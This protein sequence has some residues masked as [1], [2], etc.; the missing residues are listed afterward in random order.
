MKGGQCHIMLIHWRGPHMK[1]CLGHVHD[2]QLVHISVLAEVSL[3]PSSQWN[4]RPR[5]LVRSYGSSVLNN[6]QNPRCF[7]EQTINLVAASPEPSQM[8]KLLTRCIFP[9]GLQHCW[10]FLGLLKMKEVYNLVRCIKLQFPSYKFS[11]WPPSNCPCLHRCTM[12]LTTT[13]W[14]L[15]SSVQ[16]AFM[17]HFT[18]E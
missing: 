18:T 12:L 10:L 11:F 7:P 6:F 5:N 1:I 4:N 15:L 16:Q 8:L 17:K 14:A 13:C 9:K 3:S 2:T